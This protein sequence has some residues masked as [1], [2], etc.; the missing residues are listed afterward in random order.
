MVAMRGVVGIGLILVGV[1]W[2]TNA[3]PPERP[4]VPVTV[5]RDRAKVMHEV[6]SATLESMHHHF[7]RRDRAVL[8]AR[9]M[10][11]VFR[12]VDRRTGMKSRWIAVN[13]PAMSL[14]H[15]A[16]TSFEKKAVEELSAGKGETEAV[17]EGVYYRATPI[18]LG[19]GC[20]GCHTK[21]GAIDER[22]PRFA[23]LVIAIPVEK[24]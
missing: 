3:A 23:G 13:T 2:T 8:P 24:P 11:D 5:A 15:E 22:K 20:V 18:P 14:N 4:T 6:Y 1:V 16:E 21:F 17:V 9:A 19:A 7:F 12:D 10:D